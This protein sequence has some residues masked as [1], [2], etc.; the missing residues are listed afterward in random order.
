MMVQLQEWIIGSWSPCFGVCRHSVGCGISRVSWSESADALIIA[1][2]IALTIQFDDA[3]S[4]QEFTPRFGRFWVGAP[5]LVD[6]TGEAEPSV[7]SPPFTFLYY[8]RML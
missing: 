3:W 2:F 8:A 7:F 1:E 4:K 6:F 5:N